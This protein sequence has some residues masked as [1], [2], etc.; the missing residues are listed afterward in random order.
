MDDARILFD[1]MTKAE[2]ICWNAMIDGYTQDVDTGCRTNL[3]AATAESG[4]WLHSYPR[5]GTALNLELQVCVTL[6]NAVAALQAQGPSLTNITFVGLQAQGTCL[7]TTVAW[8]TFSILQGSWKKHYILS[9]LQSI[10][11]KPDN[12]G[13]VTTRCMLAYAVSQI[14]N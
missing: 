4:W 8:P 10:T 3:P 9:R 1:G 12:D 6:E 13:G 7:S 14:A 5:I 2:S 11:I